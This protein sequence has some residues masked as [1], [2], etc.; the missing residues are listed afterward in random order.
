MKKKKKNNDIQNSMVLLASEMERGAAKNVVNIDVIIRRVCLS[1]R[2]DDAFKKWVPWKIL[3]R[4]TYK[5]VVVVVDSME[6][7]SDTVDTVDM[8]EESYHFL[9]HLLIYYDV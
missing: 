8:V 6:Y 7:Y 2:I 1:S 3:H 4:D 5:V 9:S